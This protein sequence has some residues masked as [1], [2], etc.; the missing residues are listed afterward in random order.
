MPVAKHGIELKGQERPERWV[1][2]PEGR[3]ENIF[4]RIILAT[5]LQSKGC[6]WGYDK[7]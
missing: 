1:S 2:V 3:H 7:G 6:S 5:K 4:W